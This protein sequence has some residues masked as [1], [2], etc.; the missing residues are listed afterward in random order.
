MGVIAGT[1]RR[2]KSV[3]LGRPAAART[4]A[5]LAAVVDDG[6]EQTITDGLTDPDV[7]RVITATASGT[8]GDIAAV[9]VRVTGT[10]FNGDEITE[11]LPAFTVDTR[12]TVTGRMAFKSVTEVVI[13]RHDG[14][15]ATTAIG[16]AD[17]LGIP[18]RLSRDT[19]LA[20][21]LGG[22]REA[23]RPSVATSATDVSSN[24]VDLDSALD[25]NEVIIDYY[26]TDPQ[27]RV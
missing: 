26:P 24:T 3:T 9:Q 20:A 25:G 6:T 27:E 22:A 19:V 18:D 7:P 8:A 5:V 11:T 16:V 10:D 17:A 13:P 2:V 4:D 15:G 12:G 23:T 14:T 1:Q 21:F